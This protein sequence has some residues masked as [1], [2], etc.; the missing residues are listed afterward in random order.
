MDF[1]HPKVQQVFG[2]ADAIVFQR[3]VLTP[4]VIAAM[5]YWSALGKIVTIDLDDAYPSLPP[6]NPAHAFWILNRANLP[7]GDP[8][9]NLCDAMLHA[10]ALIS[11]SKIIIKDYEHLVPGFWIPNYP[12][13]KW[14]EKIT[15]KPFGAPDI[16]L[17]YNQE[18]DESGQQKTILVGKE[19]EA[20][21]GWIVLGWGGSISHVDSWVYSGIVEAL[22]R[23]F[24]EDRYANVRLKFCGSET[25]L[26]YILNKWG[27]KVIRQGGVSPEHW[28][29]VVA[30]FDIGLAPLDMRPVASNTW[31][32]GEEKWGGGEYSYDE[33]RSWL[34]GVEYLCAGVPWLGTKCATYIDLERHGHLVKNGEENW[35]K[36]LTDMIDNIQSR[37]ILA[38]DKRKWALKKYTMEANVHQ[39]AAVYERIG[40]MKRSKGGGTLPNI[41]W[42]RIKYE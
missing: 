34:K 38:V 18:T 24:A 21:A 22:N 33:R 13:R 31:K 1:N 16:E 15:P 10:D 36:A 6:S 41:L 32:E 20:S 25:R 7:S 30:T 28:P 27:S 42:N 8:V 19:R 12:Y 26:D 5:D 40:N 17:G 23:V 37:K 9:K 14:Y 3:N 29:Y 39:Y 35:Y 4:D 11:P 2:K